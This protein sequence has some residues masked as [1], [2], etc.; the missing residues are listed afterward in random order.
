MK[1]IIRLSLLLLTLFLSGFCT[2]AFGAQAAEG[3]KD[4]DVSEFVLEHLA[5]SYEWHIT[6]WNGKPI[7]VHLPV[8]VKGKESGWHVFSS[9]RLEE[10][11]HQGKDYQGF[12]LSSEHHNK[13]YEKLADG[14]V[15][16]P[17]DLSITKNVLQIWLVVFILIGTFLYCARWYKKHD[18]V[19]QEAPKGFVG[20][21]EMLVMTIHDDVIKF[22]PEVPMSRA[23]ST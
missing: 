21:I 19:K 16:R 12:F 20:A 6:T 22:F 3:K 14:T 9:E 18:S 11:A 1:K 13:I 15:E 5:D 7:S 10:A 17:W 23:T 2:E 8:I 4:I